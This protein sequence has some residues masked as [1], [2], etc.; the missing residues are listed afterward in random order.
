MRTTALTL[1][2]F[3]VD[4]GSTQRASGRDLGRGSGFGGGNGRRPRLLVQEH[5]TS[6]GPSGWEVPGT[7][8][9]EERPWWAA[10]RTVGGPQRCVCR[11]V[12]PSLPPAPRAPSPQGPRV[13]ART[14]EPRPAASARP[15]PETLLCH[16]ACNSRAAD[17][18]SPAFIPRLR[19]HALTLT[20]SATP[21]H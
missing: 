11:P 7:S 3:P 18:G 19:T 15:R 17:F 16:V 9:G 20:E 1:T 21:P 4:S 14:S 2:L 8:R 5:R 6:G 12:R 10:L 13:P